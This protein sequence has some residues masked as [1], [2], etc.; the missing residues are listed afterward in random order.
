MKQI[1][2]K[3][4]DEDK[5]KI[6]K[7]AKDKG[8]TVT[9]LIITSVLYGKEECIENGKE[10]INK[11][12]LDILNNQLEIKD[13]QIKNLNRLLDQQQQ[14]NLKNMNLLEENVDETKEVKKSWFDWFKK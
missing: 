9:E 13:E 12:V 5:E 8:L 1:N 3:L 4:S 2:I 7:L 10:E 14:L 6:D 11:D